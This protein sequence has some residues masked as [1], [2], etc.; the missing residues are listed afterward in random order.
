MEV[1]I[2]HLLN[3]V[4]LQLRLVSESI[5]P[6]VIIWIGL[7]RPFYRYGGHIE[8]TRFKE[9]YGMPRGHSLSIYAR[10]SGQRRTS[11]NIS[12]EKGDDYY[13]QIL[14]NDFFRITIFFLGKLKEKLA[15]KRA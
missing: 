13:V 10:F 15:R 11:L 5:Q 14:R 1:S 7:N 2:F 3:I 4:K 9:Y 8:F 12:R 6:V